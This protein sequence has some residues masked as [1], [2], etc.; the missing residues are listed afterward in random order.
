MIKE[1]AAT[2]EESIEPAAKP[3]EAKKNIVENA[4]S[5]R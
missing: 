5:K 1:K 4:M 3:F 2:W